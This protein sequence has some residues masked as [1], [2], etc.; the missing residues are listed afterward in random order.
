MAF[1]IGDRAVIVRSPYPEWIGALCTVTSG[2]V[3]AV[4]DDET[5]A[6]DPRA[7]NGQPVHQVMLDDE[8]TEPWIAYAPSDL[9]PLPSD[10]SS[11]ST[12]AELPEWARRACG[13]KERV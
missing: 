3:P 7:E 10:S 2:L 12:W 8:P 11:K 13:W 6:D 1:R 9:E 5:L 4:W